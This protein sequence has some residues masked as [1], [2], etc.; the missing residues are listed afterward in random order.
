MILSLICALRS[1]PIIRVLLFPEL[2][3]ALG[4]EFQTDIQPSEIIV[5]GLEGDDVTSL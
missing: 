1:Q 2:H 5:D 4:G 3:N